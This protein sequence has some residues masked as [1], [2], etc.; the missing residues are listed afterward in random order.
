MKQRSYRVF[1]KYFQEFSK[2]CHLSLASDVGEGGELQWIVKKHN[3]SWTPCIWVIRGLN[4]FDEYVKRLIQY[5][6]PES[7]QEIR[8]K[9]RTENCQKVFNFRILPYHAAFSFYS[10]QRRGG[11]N[12]LKIK[13]KCFHY[14]W[15]FH[16][17]TPLL[18]PFHLLSWNIRKQSW[19]KDSVVK[20]FLILLGVPYF[21][22]P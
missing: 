7:F 2:V 20:L 21:L 13:E 16:C 6:P 11:W 4:F 18:S 14:Y 19:R 9:D 17:H 10:V 15:L 3:S 1:I 22:F 8:E 5:F 12:F